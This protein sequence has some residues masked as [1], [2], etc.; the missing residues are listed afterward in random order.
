MTVAALMVANPVGSVFDPRTGLLW[1]AGTDGPDHF[2]LIPATP[3]QLA[4]ANALPV[5]GTILNTTIGVVAT[6]APLDTLAARRLA[7]TAHDGLARAIRP[8]HSPL[9]GD[10]IFVLATGTA[11]APEPPPL[12][13]AFPTDL[14]VLDQLCTAAAVCVER[15]IVDAILSARSLAGIPSYTELFPR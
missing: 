2:G 12:P 14:L 10:T 5:K 15:A 8:A 11:T 4:V 9:D 1:G 3:E 6:D 13:P 7:T